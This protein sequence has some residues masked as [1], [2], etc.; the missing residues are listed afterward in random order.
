MCDRP[1][2]SINNRTYGLLGD[3]IEGVI[4]PD[5]GRYCSLTR[6]TPFI[7]QYLAIEIIWV[8]YSSLPFLPSGRHPKEC[9]RRRQWFDQ[10]NIM[11][12][13]ELID[14]HRWL[15][16]RVSLSLIWHNCIYSVF[17]ECWRLITKAA[18]RRWSVRHL[19]LWISVA[20]SNYYRNTSQ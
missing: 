2:L 10:L 15:I 18:W 19:E 11:P 12:I 5:T 7:R 13:D 6:S 9:S 17:Y 14:I 4:Q 16:S 8:V 3:V 1:I 20:K